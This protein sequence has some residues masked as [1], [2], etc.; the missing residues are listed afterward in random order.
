MGDGELPLKVGVLDP[1]LGKDPVLST[2]AWGPD[3]VVRCWLLFELNGEWDKV[4]IATDIEEHE[5]CGDITV[6]SVAMNC[7]DVL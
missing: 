5:W 1:E 2:I 7:R 3:G 4:A 6:I